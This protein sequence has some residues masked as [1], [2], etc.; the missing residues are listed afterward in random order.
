[1]NEQEREAIYAMREWA[2]EGEALR[3]RHRAEQHAH[4]QQG[5]ALCSLARTLG[6]SLDEVGAALSV[7]DRYPRTRQSLAAWMRGQQ[8]RAKDDLDRE[9]RDL[10]NEDDEP[11]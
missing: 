5:L 8:S 9:L 3:E 7:P 10:L 2:L 11:S 6:L 1:M 4:D